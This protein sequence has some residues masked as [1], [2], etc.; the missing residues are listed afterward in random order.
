LLRITLVL[1]LLIPGFSRADDGEIEDFAEL[2]LEELLDV[3][4]AA[5]KH[6]QSI[7]WSPSA[8]TVFT[9]EDIQS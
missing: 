6:K 8:I 3:V 7:I 5:S 9:R 1:A 2:D 4:F